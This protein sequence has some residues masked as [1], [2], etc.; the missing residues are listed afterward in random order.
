MVVAKSLNLQGGVPVVAQRV[1]TPTVMW[2]M[3][4][5]PGLILGHGQWV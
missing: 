5:D 2:S 1:E 3:D 4:E